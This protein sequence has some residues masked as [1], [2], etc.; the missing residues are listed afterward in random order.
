MASIVF[1]SIYD[2]INIGVKSLQ[3]QILRNGHQS[4]IIFFKMPCVVL[5]DR[6]KKDSLCYEYTINDNL[7]ASNYDVAPW[8]EAELDLL[9]SEI[10]HLA[11][12]VLALS[13]RSWFD[14]LAPAFATRIRECV[15]NKQLLIV[16]GGYG[17]SFNVEHY[18]RSCDY[19]LVGECEDALVDF[20]DNL[21]ELVRA[22]QTL[23]NLAFM[24]DG[25]LHANEP[26]PLRNNFSSYKVVPIEEH[27]T[28]IQNGKILHTDPI[29]INR[30]RYFLLAGR[31]CVGSCSYCSGGYWRSIYRTPLPKRRNRPLVAIR[32]EL[33]QVA[34]LGFRYIQFV[35]EF[36][37]FPRKDLMDLF[38][39]MRT[40][41]R[42]PFFCYLHPQMIVEHP[43][44]LESAV[45]AGLNDTIIA[46]QS[47][48][49]DFSERVYHRKMKIEQLHRFAE[50]IHR[51]EHVA[52]KYHFITGNPLEPDAVLIETMELIKTLP[53]R[54]G[55][56][57]INAF[58][59]N[60]FPMSPLEKTFRECGAGT[61]ATEKSF[62][63]GLFHYL[64]LLVDDKTMESII[65]EYKDGSRPF[66][67]QKIVREHS[68]AINH[69][70]DSQTP[71][72][73]EGLHG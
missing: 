30:S 14:S 53:F 69:L 31:G 40:E 38:E 17:P 70:V 73:K 12:D 28:L 44:I 19:V 18:A 13:C 9:V 63:Y 42:I 51:H 15:D 27:S 62:T 3:Y 54:H 35:D 4:H 6:I 2:S 16:A 36:F 5:T 48:S 11:P 65:R 61:V 49:P 34:Q 43:E 41:I 68:L 29:D 58:K 71:Q 32:E 52:K 55:K 21:H 1:L 23:G 24:K 46:F 20:L 57:T 72:T 66:E 47:G 25:R 50:L 7:Y 33:A 26:V 67:L 59:L 37:V 45:S 56:D 10:N 64:R 60:I 8:T 39:F 22:R